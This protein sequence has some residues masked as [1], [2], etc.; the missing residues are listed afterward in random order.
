MYC[1]KKFF[2]VGVIK[3]DDRFKYFIDIL[4][5][6]YLKDLDKYLLE[7]VISKSCFFKYSSFF[8]FFFWELDDDNVYFCYMI[9]K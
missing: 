7:N 6:V 9:F 4:N 2:S 1:G 3:I 8:W 5:F